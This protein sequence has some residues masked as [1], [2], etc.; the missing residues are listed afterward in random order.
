MYLQRL[1]WLMA[2]TCVVSPVT[3]AA[4]VVTPHPKAQLAP[5][6]FLV[7]SRNLI[8]PNFSQTVILLIQYNDDGALGVVI[9]RPTDVAIAKLLPEFKNRTK[10][11]DLV[12]LGGPVDP[13]QMV[14]LARAKHQPKGSERVA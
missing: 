1:F 11:K 2:A 7:A 10:Q 3:Q 14:L 6:T 12:Y 8:D 4:T 5:G 13:R 9:N